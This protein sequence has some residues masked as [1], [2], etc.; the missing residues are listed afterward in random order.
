MV[1]NRNFV[2]DEIK[3]ERTRDVLYQDLIRLSGKPVKETVIKKHGN[4]PV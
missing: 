2:D 3:P 4:M 1:L